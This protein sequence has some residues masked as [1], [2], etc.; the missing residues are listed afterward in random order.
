MKNV[1]HHTERSSHYLIFCLV[2]G[3]SG[4]FFGYTSGILAG[5][6]PLLRESFSITRGSSGIIVSIPLFAAAIGAFCTG[7]LID[8]FGRRPLLI[9]LGGL[10]I[11]G[12]IHTALADHI[13]W[14]LFGQI[15][16]GLSIGISSYLVPIY[17]SEL[18]PLFARGSMVFLYAM[19]INAGFLLAFLVVYLF[20][21]TG[22]WRLMYGLGLIPTV[23]Y[24]IGS[25]FLP[26][27]ARFIIL[28]KREVE[29]KETLTLLKRIK[30]I[31]T[32]TIQVIQTT[33]TSTPRLPSKIFQKPIA[34]VLGFSIVL[35]IIQQFTGVNTVIFFAPQILTQGG[36]VEESAA[37]MIAIG[38]SAIML[39]FTILAVFFIDF[40]GRRAMLMGGLAGMTLGHLFIAYALYSDAN[41]P[42]DLR[43]ALVG[44]VIYLASYAMSAGPIV[45]LYVAEMIPLG[46]RGI[47][48][49]VAI[50]I[51]WVSGAVLLIIFQ[52]LLKLI[53]DGPI[54]LCFAFVSFI[55]AILVYLMA[56]ETT[57]IPLEEIEAH[58][59]DN[60][61]IRELGAPH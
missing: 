4:I 53:G 14:F 46:V 32:D 23:I 5:A 58:L 20:Y 59:L 18:A 26:E 22:E 9:F 56:P 31:T 3:L 43:I 11:Y 55:S 35:A 16:I 49:S 42:L 2:A 7:R 36:I 10:I 21:P 57:A 13:H 48:A 6:L 29:H 33:A 34:K 38:V 27:S 12:I 60:K 44:I 8:A 24:F 51:I 50:G 1:S 54:Y 40:V 39:L 41:L 37:A 15:C 17:L 28:K 61:T 30:S 45:W 19:S 52:P 25:L 47:G